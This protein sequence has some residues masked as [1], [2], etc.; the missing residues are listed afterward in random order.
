MKYVLAIDSFKGCMSSV[1]VEE[2]V[3][4]TLKKQG[5]EVVAFPMSDA[6]I[7]ML[8]ALTDAFG[9]GGTI[10][11]ALA[12]VLK[13]CKFTLA[14]DVRNPLYG[15]N[16]AARVFGRQ[17]GATEE[18]VDALDA[19]A[20]RF[21]DFSARHFGFDRSQDAGAGAAGGL[22]YAFLQYLNA[23]AQSGA[24][25]LLDLIGFDSIIADADVVITGEGHADRQTLM[26]KL[27]ERILQRAKKH[28]VPVWLMA[29]Q[30]S[31]KE[32]LLDAGFSTVES[33]TPEG[34][35]VKE[36]MKPEV[37]RENIRSWIAAIT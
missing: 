34:M 14:S 32:A 21:A 35:P 10:D 4:D 26:G 19:K 18:M 17:K 25:L 9:K 11:D 5:S 24:D 30:V 13:D 22:G 1:E 2:T 23:K 31:D 27:P 29:G 37:T 12:G 7:G 33:I 8:E 20:R 28:A 3:G 15:E 6:G 36:A 16:G